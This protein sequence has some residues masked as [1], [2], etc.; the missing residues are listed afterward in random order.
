MVARNAMGCSTRRAA[1][2]ASRESMAKEGGSVNGDSRPPLSRTRATQALHRILIAK[3][4]SF[5]SWDA[6]DTDT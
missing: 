5:F 2:T 6:C 3:S 1:H 4:Q